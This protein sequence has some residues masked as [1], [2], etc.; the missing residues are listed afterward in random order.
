MI[1][2]YQQVGGKNSAVRYRCRRSR[3]GRFR[4]VSADG[5][6][7]ASGAIPVIG[8]AYTLN[9]VAG[10]YV[11]DPSFDAAELLNELLSTPPEQQAQSLHALSAPGHTIPALAD[12]IE[13]LAITRVSDA[14]RTS[15]ATF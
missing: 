12:E 7:P 15:A 13:K 11:P 6:Q 8:G 14:L 2:S 5:Q 3:A 4:R 10:E 1:G 9:N